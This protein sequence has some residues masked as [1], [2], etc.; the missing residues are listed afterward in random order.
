MTCMARVSRHCAGIVVATLVTAATS[1]RPVAAQAAEH[2]AALESLRD[3]LAPIVDTVSLRAL[4]RRLIGE[5]RQRR[6]DGML[7]L[8]L[9]FIALRLGELAGRQH[10][11]DAGSEFQW[12]TELQPRWPYG[13]LGLGL[14]E[15]GVGDSEVALVQGLQT[16]LGRD[17]LVR[18]ANAFARS[19]EVDPEFVT[20]LVQLSNTS[21]RQRM[22]A[23]L[24]V[25]LAALR[26]AAGTPAA[27]HPDLLLARGRVERE[28]GSLDSAMAAVDT[29]L[30]TRPRAGDA[31]LE[32]ARIRFAMGRVDGAAPWFRGA[33]SAEVEAGRRVL[34]ALSQHDP[35]LRPWPAREGRTTTL[36]RPR[37]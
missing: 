9:G 31:Q 35:A 29:L 12:V 17:A 13:W 1:T 22:N 33:A 2:R 11:E 34:S 32:L 19:A 14:A 5:A 26:R 20:G 27:R 4:E 36:L 30:A 15:L 28:V 37:L 24:D 8:R 6:D 23:R 25:A 18:S 16:M 10:F 21:L 3:S 7:H